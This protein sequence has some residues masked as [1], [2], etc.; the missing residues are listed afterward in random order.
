V[1]DTT[2]TDHELT[3]LRG[4]LVGVGEGVDGD[5]RSDLLAGG[6]S[7]LTYLLTDDVSR[8]VLRRPP[9]AGLTPSAH[10]M[11]REFRVTHA[12]QSTAVPVART[13]GLEEDPALLGAPFSIV[14]FVEGATI[15]SSED[16]GLL[17]DVQVAACV[18]SLVATLS[19]LHAVD[20]LGVGLER[21]GRPDAYAQRQLHRWSGQW[22]HV[23]THDV[24]DATVLLGQLMDRAPTSGTAAIVHGDYRI[25]NTIV[26]A[27]EPS[28]IRALVDWELSTIGDPVADVA[29]MCAYRH[30]A[31]D[32][33]LGVDAA[34]TSDRLPDADE[35]AGLY[36]KVSGTTLVNWDFFLGLGFYKLAVIAQGIDFRLRAGAAASEGSERAGEAVPRLL[37]AGLEVMAR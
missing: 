15:R 4:Y 16:L 11:G 29:M 28:V 24:P 13:V 10:D 3:G 14:G 33:I 35:L 30:P 6:R 22:E 18:E 17:D 5:L 32:D 21:F 23:A 27:D 34:W 37:A 36:E 7:N 9:R 20:H 26:D 8:W 19:A 31:L 25:D 2:L 1:S 12:L